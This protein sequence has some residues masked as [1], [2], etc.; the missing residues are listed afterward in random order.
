[1]ASTLSAQAAG[2]TVTLDVDGSPCDF[3]VVQQGKPDDSYDDSCDGTWLMMEGLYNEM[4]WGGAS[5][6]KYSASDAHAWL[7]DD[8]LALLDPDILAMV[9]T[10]KIPVADGAA[11]LTGADGLEAKAFLPSAREV[12]W[13]ASSFPVEGSCLDFFDGFSNSDDRRMAY[14][15]AGASKNWFTR[16]YVRSSGRVAGILRSSGGPTQQDPDAIMFL[17]PVMIFPSGTLVSDSGAIQPNSPPAVTS[18]SGTDG[19]N[20]GVRNTPFLLEYTAAD[21]DGGSLTLTEALDGETTRTLTAASGVAQH[22]AAVNDPPAFLQLENGAHTLQVTASDG[23]ASGSLGLTFT[24]AVT[25]ASLTL[26]QPIAAS[27]PIKAA[28]L[29]VGGSIPADAD[30]SV[31]VTNNAL[32]PAPVWQDATNEVRQGGNI[33]FSNRTAA[34]SPAFNFRIQAA[35]GLSGTGGYIDSVTGAF[36]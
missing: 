31:E 11:V 24:K 10:V 5:T 36:Q 1:M 33:V 20:I 12:G 3:L 32:D 6:N 9:K 26:T 16:T 14:D 30:Y 17:R 13:V 22:F 18:P 8:F 28:V 19:A 35:R 29:T 34:E 25:S 15:S 21:P 7:N 27:A 4:A 23:A 2:S